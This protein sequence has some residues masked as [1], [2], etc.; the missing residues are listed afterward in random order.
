VLASSVRPSRGRTLTPRGGKS[1]WHVSG[2]TASIYF[3]EIMNLAP[4]IDGI[5]CGDSEV[6]LLKILDG[7]PLSQIPNAVFR[8]GPVIIENQE[9]W[10]ANSDFLEALV[11][12]DLSL[13]DDR[14]AYFTQ[15]DTRLGIPL[16]GSRGCW[17]DCGYCGGSRSAF[18]L[19]GGRDAVAVRS[20]K[21]LV[22]D[23][24]LAYDCGARKFLISQPTKRCEAAL[25]E[26]RRRFYGNVDFTLN[27]EPWDIPSDVLLCNYIELCH[28][29]MDRPQLLISV[30]GSEE[31]E[32]RAVERAK[33]LE[34][35]RRVTNMSNN[36][37]VTIFDGYFCA[38]QHEESELYNALSFM[39]QCRLEFSGRPVNA[40]LMAYSTDPASRWSLDQEL[41]STSID[42]SSISRGLLRTSVTADNLLLSRPK[43]LAEKDAA[44]FM[45]VLD[46]NEHLY[47]R[48]PAL[49]FALIA[50]IGEKATVILLREIAPSLYIFDD[51][52][53]YPIANE[54]AFDV[55]VLRALE[56][57]LTVSPLGRPVESS[58][59]LAEFAAL[60]RAW[61]YACSLGKNGQRCLLGVDEDLLVFDPQTIHRSHFSFDRLL[62][63]WKR[64][65]AVE[66]KYQGPREEEKGTF[67]YTL[68]PKIG[69]AL[70]WREIEQLMRFNGITPTSTVIDA[71]AE[72]LDAPRDVI[73]AR[74]S[75]LAAAGT[76]RS[77]H[78]T[79]PRS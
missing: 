7:T 1:Q 45:A 32:S 35:T 11:Y 30:H 19:H 58:K 68:L 5:I 38:W 43:Q 34:L 9:K 17:Y 48:F 18:S 39:I 52:Y 78:A 15:L 74:V 8:N 70:P 46:A 60:F 25:L 63:S 42:L 4:Y 57:G 61:A 59:Y 53:A 54:G 49:W 16:A 72:D 51:G 3:K 24:Q 50:G 71:L 75:Q 67:F 62:S 65:T 64:S 22:D 69:K 55:L 27:I 36:I 10:I 73:R 56:S 44:L 76:L 79:A 2:I 6:P 66:M 14:E 23:L 28:E 40:A 21:R 26:I 33:I 20:I 29:Q 47:R 41:F 37:Q 12:G 31:R 77:I 13:I